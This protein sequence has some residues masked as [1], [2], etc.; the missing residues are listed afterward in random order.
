MTKSNLQNPPEN[1]AEYTSNRLIDKLLT[2]LKYGTLLKHGRRKIALLVSYLFARVCG[3]S[4]K[5]DLSTILDKP[6][7]VVDVGA[8]DGPSKIWEQFADKLR[9][10]LV[11]PEPESYKIIQDRFKDDIRIRCLQAALSSMNGPRNLY[12][13]KWPRASSVHPVREDFRQQIFLRDH[14]ETKQIIPIECER[15]DLHCTNI[16][17]IK[18]DV[19]GHDLHVIKGTGNLM[20]NCIGAQLEVNFNDL[21]REG[22]MTFSDIDQYMRSFGFI[23]TEIRSPGYWHFLLPS[24]H[25]ESKGFI[26]ASD[27]LYF[28]FPSD[29]VQQIKSGAWPKDKLAKALALYLAYGNYEFTFVLLQLA[30]KEK[31]LS[32]T[33]I[34]YIK[35][36]NLIERRSGYNKLI[37]YKWIKRLQE[38]ISGEKHTNNLGY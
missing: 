15:L 31:L 25:L 32:I 26:A 6:V 11:E 21:W 7:D 19:E 10:T 1:V 20:N 23:I 24:P 35:T 34:L 22:Q 33:D 4:L 14:F 3:V 28:R 8:S 18:T 13:V 9:L 36:M 12:V 2:A 29:I 17:F 30:T 5:V 27:F 16:D 37:T 38:F